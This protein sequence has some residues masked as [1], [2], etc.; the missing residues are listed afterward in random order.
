[1]PKKSPANHNKLYIRPSAFPVSINDTNEKDTTIV[2]LIVSCD[3][4]AYFLAVWIKN[5]INIYPESS[6][7]MNVVL[8]FEI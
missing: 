4:G 5:T 6:L 3:E 8:G 7:S 2:E 1:M